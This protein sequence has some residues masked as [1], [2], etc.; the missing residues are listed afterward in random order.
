MRASGL[1]LSIE[2]VMRVLRSSHQCNAL[3]GSKGSASCSNFWNPH[4]VIHRHSLID[5][6]SIYMVTISRLSAIFAPLT[7]FGLSVI[8]APLTFSMERGKIK[9][10]TSIRTS[11]IPWLSI[12]ITAH[13]HYPNPVSPDHAKDAYAPEGMSYLMF[14]SISPTNSNFSEGGTVAG[15]VAMTN[16]RNQWCAVWYLYTFSEYIFDLADSRIPMMKLKIARKRSSQTFHWVNRL[17]S[18]NCDDIH[19]NSDSYMNTEEMDFQRWSLYPPL[20][21]WQ[22]SLKRPMETLLRYHRQ[23]RRWDM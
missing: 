15:P 19:W 20:F 1:C 17:V 21:W 10:K 4:F 23:E 9:D 11:P 14:D 2:V 12:L 18:L 13:P 6:I 22:G 7:H 16:Q 3:V 8:S 5:T